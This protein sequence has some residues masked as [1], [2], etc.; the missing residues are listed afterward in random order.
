MRPP[1]VNVTISKKAQDI[2]NESI[3]NEKKSVPGSSKDNLE[4]EKKDLKRA[5]RKEEKNILPEPK[6]K[7]QTKHIGED[8]TKAKRIYE[9]DS[10]SEKGSLKMHIDS[11]HEGKKP[12]KCSFCENS[13]SQKG[14][15][16][17][18]IDSVHE[19]KKPYKCSLCANSFSQKGILKTHIDSVHEGKKPYKCS[20]CENSFSQKANLKMHI[21]SKHEGKKPYKC[22][23]C[24]NSFSQKGNLKIH[25][26]SKHVG[27]KPYKC[28]LCENSFSQKGGLKIHIDS[29]H[30]GKK[31]HK[32]SEFFFSNFSQRYELTRKPYKCSFCENS[33]SQQGS[34]KMHIDSVHEGK[35]P[36]K[37]SLCESSFSQ[38]SSLKM[39][40]DSVHE[41]KK[42]HKSSKYFFSNIS[43]RYQLKCQSGLSVTNTKQPCE[44]ARKPGPKSST[45]KFPPKNPIVFKEFNTTTKSSTFNSCDI[46]LETPEVQNI[47]KLVTVGK[48]IQMNMED[49]MSEVKEEMVDSKESPL[50]F[51]NENTTI[52]EEFVERNL[53]LF[54]DKVTYIDGEGSKDFQVESENDLHGM[55]EEILDSKD[56]P[57]SF[58][59][60]KNMDQ[61]IPSASQEVPKEGRRKQELLNKIKSILREKEKKSRRT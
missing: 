51:P 24:E 30:E 6:K 8:K 19:G 58:L 49:N 42:P 57:L 26:D 47:G 38:K 28:S 3:E 29:V 34:L 1:G 56:D 33:F 22:S 46:E 21:D 12:Y 50:P 48:D 61:H 32:S 31:P 17:T 25:I 9:I 4:R 2:F 18:H 13:F 20:L 7:H 23:F 45:E 44:V 14:I 16:K 52:F 40:I 27:K 53:N 36:Y 43:Q 55:E 39:H 37:C 5:K 11:K 54:I 41:G 59:T 15:L 60:N 35:K 10:N